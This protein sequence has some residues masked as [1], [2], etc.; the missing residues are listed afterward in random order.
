MLKGECIRLGTPLSLDDARR[1]VEGYVKHHN[2]VRLNSAIGYVT[3]K[4][5]PARRH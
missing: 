3:P 4:D 5:I 2:H 1:R